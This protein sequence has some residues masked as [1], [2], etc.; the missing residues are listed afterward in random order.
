MSS[1]YNLLESTLTNI[2]DY[3]V[4][5]L[6][7]A[8]D[9]VNSLVT[10][11]YTLA[12]PVMHFCCL[13]RI[14]DGASLSL[15]GAGVDFDTP[16]TGYQTG[17]ILFEIIVLLTGTSLDGQSSID[18][19]AMRF[20][21]ALSALFM[22]D[23]TFGGLTDITMLLKGDVIKQDYDSNTIAISYQGTSDIYIV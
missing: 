16:E 13:P 20:S 4:A 19:L 17:K 18:L 5:N 3:I 2:Y 6:P 15:V 8:I 1:K 23:A 9:N 12:Y 7:E 22:K 21:D 14:N 11:G 10:D